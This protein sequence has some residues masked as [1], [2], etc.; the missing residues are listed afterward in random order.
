[1]VWFWHASES[2]HLCGTKQG[3]FLAAVPIP[4]I[5]FLLTFLTEIVVSECN[6]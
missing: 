5:V 6:V 4:A 3:F 1:M 2:V